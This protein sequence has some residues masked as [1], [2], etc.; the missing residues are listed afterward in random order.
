MILYKHIFRGLNMKID[1]HGE[2]LDEKGIIDGK[3]RIV[4]DQKYFRPTEVDNLLGDSSLA[5]EE[6]DWKP[7]ISFDQL[8]D[9]MIANDYGS[10]KSK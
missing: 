3:E 8:V 10:V 4:I 6:L 1:W 5:L 7:K 9:E 2:G